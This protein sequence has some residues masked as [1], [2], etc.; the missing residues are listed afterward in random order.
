MNKYINQLL[1]MQELS[2]ALRENGFL[3]GG[4]GKDSSAYD[5]LKADIDG[6]KSILPHEVS[7][8]YDRI[9]KKYEITVCPLIKDVCT[10]CFIKIPVGLSNNVRSANFCISCPNCGRFLYFD[11]GETPR[12]GQ[13]FHQY[14][15]VARFSSPDLMLPNIQAKSKEDA[16][17]K[18]GEATA[19]A[20]FVEDKKSFVKSLLK[21]EKLISTAVGSGI[22]FPHARGVKACGLTLAVGTLKPSVKDADGAPLNIL[23]V[24]AV[25]TQASMFYLELISKLANYFAKTENR[26]KFL[27]CADG[28]SMW[29]ILV[30]IGK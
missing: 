5:E 19:G 23:L 28:D 15:G 17:E 3:K 8:C 7:A 24:S 4:S 21:R 29:K 26:K 10:G 6:L 16:I 30:Q 22:A 25:P 13:H 1:Q 9:S 11:D 20:G 12:P 14:K 27:S 2:I 18:I